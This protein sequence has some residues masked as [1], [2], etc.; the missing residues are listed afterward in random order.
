[1]EST[2]LYDVFGNETRYKVIEDTVVAY[3]ERATIKFPLPEASVTAL[4]ELT[5]GSVSKI[6][7]AFLEQ[8]ELKLVSVGFKKAKA[9]TMAMI[10]CAVAEEQKVNPLTF[11]EVNT[12]TLKLTVDTYKTINA[13]RPPGNRVNVA[14][15][16]TNHRSRYTSL[17]KP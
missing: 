11:F 15:P 13:M 6:K 9:K 17:I 16:L 1:M 12:N 3:L 14:V 2:S 10:L 8:V 4:E 7:H 5:K